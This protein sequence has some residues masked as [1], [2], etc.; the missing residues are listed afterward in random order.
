MP[1]R[2][3]LRPP[4]GWFYRH[5]RHRSATHSGNWSLMVTEA[6]NDAQPS[7]TCAG[8]GA[9]AG[10]VLRHHYFDNPGRRQNEERP[11]G[12][13]VSQT[14][15]RRSEDPTGV[16]PVDVRS[17]SGRRAGGQ[18]GGPE[19]VDRPAASS[20][21]DRRESAAYREAEVSGYAVHE[22]RRAGPQLSHAADGEADDRWPPA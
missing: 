13:A 10:R 11:R 21:A 17:A 18:G 22:Q 6:T 3:G 8:R 19:E 7:I 14:D 2:R 5:L 9:F 16:E 20:R 1:A 12:P 15:P 4:T